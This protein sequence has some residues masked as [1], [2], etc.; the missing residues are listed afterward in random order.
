MV[1]K[2]ST[3]YTAGNFRGVKYSLFLWAGRPRRNFNVGVA[4]QNVGMPCSHETKRNFYSRIPPFLELNEF[5]TPRNLP[6]IRYTVA[7]FF[8]KMASRFAAPV[9][10]SKELKLRSSA[11][12][13]KTNACTEWGVKLWADWSRARAVEVARVNPTTPLLQMPVPDFAYWLGKFVLEIRKQTGTEYPP[14]TLCHCLLL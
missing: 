13:I 14:K 10:D 5:F 9:S 3:V 11:I 12:P 4:Y 7:I 1:R 2:I 6:A 8:D